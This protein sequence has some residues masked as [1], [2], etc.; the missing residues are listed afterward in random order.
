MNA[1]EFESERLNFHFFQL[2]VGSHSS[3]KR[4]VKGDGENTLSESHKLFKAM[5]ADI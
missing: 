2:C 5:T 4:S 3:N 1:P